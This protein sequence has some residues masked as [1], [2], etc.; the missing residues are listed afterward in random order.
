MKGYLFV[1]NGFYFRVIEGVL[2]KVCN[3][4]ICSCARD[5]VACV[6]VYGCTLRKT[7]S[8]IIACVMCVCVRRFIFIIRVGLIVCIVCVWRVRVFH[9]VFFTWKLR[10]MLL[11]L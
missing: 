10:R 9:I 2:T 8:S 3:K 4:F 5:Y 11:L 1:R 6:C 7:F